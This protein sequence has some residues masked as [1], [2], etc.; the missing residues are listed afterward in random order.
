MKTGTHDTEYEVVPIKG[1]TKKRPEFLG[2][3]KRSN[4]KD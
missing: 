2:P 1:E 3:E 4:S